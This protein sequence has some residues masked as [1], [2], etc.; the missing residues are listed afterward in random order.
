MT[1][2]NVRL[3]IEVERG[4]QG[5]PHFRTNITT[6]ASGLELRNAMWTRS[7]GSWEVAYG[8]QSTSA[9]DGNFNDVVD[10]FY[11]RHGMLHDFRFRD[12]SDYKI[13]P[14]QVIGVGNGVLSTFRIMKKYTSGPATYERRITRPD[15]ATLIVTVNNVVQ[16]LGTDFTE[17]MGVLSFMTPPSPGHDVAVSCEYDVPVRFD[18]DHLGIVAHLANVMSI[19]SLIITEVKEDA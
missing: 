14:A 5:G 12:W 19:P 11:A 10:F 8:I 15:L 18:T 9:P 4:A 3:P 17:N 1:F 2:H 13:D 7:R 16:V 6:L